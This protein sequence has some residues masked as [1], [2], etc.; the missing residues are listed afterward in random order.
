MKKHVLKG[1]DI[2]FRFNLTWI[3]K[4]AIF[5]RKYLFQRPF[6]VSMLISLILSILWGVLKH[7]LSLQSSFIYLNS[8]A[9]Y[10]PSAVHTALFFSDS[11]CFVATPPK[12]NERSLKRDHFKRKFHLPNINL[13]VLKGGNCWLCIGKFIKAGLKIRQLRC[14]ISRVRPVWFN[15]SRARCTVDV[16]QYP[17][18]TI[19]IQDGCFT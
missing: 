5:E 4:I 15:L 1:L 9:R 16:V 7:R 10:L 12:M 14:S 19:L 2:R 18:Q 8:L 3:P 17:G 6:L 13:Q 11:C